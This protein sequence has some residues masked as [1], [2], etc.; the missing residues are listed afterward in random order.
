MNV[1]TFTDSFNEEEIV[2][3]E[4]GKERATNR[5]HRRRVRRN[6]RQ[7]KFFLRRNGEKRLK[8]LD[9]ELTRQ[10]QLADITEQEF[11]SEV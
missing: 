11:C 5:H 8:H 6:K 4:K 7:K 9:N 2:E 1:T 3:I 10:E